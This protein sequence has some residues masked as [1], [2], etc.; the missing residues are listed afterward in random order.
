MFTKFTNRGYSKTI[1]SIVT[2]EKNIFELPMVIP[3]PNQPIKFPAFDTPI[4]EFP[5][6]PQI[7]QISSFPEPPSSSDS[8]DEEEDNS[9]EEELKEK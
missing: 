1:R 3:V 4:L 6:F 5:Y 9:D 8:S 7:H 2:A